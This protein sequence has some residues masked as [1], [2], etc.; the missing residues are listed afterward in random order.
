MNVGG[1]VAFIVMG[2]DTT[3]CVDWDSCSELGPCNQVKKLTVRER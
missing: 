2:G 1:V 3:F